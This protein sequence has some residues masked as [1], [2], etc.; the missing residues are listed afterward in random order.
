MCTQV[1]VAGSV[2]LPDTFDKA[3]FSGS[4]CKDTVSMSHAT[5]SSLTENTVSNRISLL[6][7]SMVPYLDL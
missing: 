5:S 1:R 7:E 4:S 6:L 2:G 3:L